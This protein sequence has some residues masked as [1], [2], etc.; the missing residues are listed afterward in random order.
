M[1]YEVPLDTELY[2]QQLESRA[3]IVYSTSEIWLRVQP[4]ESG[5]WVA[6]L[7]RRISGD[8]E[9][10]SLALEPWGGNAEGTG[11][12]AQAALE[13]FAGA[14]DARELEQDKLGR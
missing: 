2:R 12:T 6:D 3:R 1:K 11:A 7:H 5:E 9:D 8:A 14:L 4:Q 13:E 10:P